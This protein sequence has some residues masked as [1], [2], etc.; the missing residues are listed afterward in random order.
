MWDLPR[1]GIAPMS[2][3]L[4]AWFFTTEQPGKPYLL[5]STSTAPL[6]RWQ[7]TILNAQHSIQN[8]HY[9]MFNTEDSK[10]HTWYIKLNIQHS[11]QDT[12]APKSLLAYRLGQLLN[13]LLDTS[14]I[15]KLRTS[16]I[17]LSS[18]T[19]PVSPSIFSTSVDDQQPQSL[20]NCQVIPFWN[21]FF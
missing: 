10:Y 2:S 3:A 13:C 14:W 19:K 21:I 12:G 1:S 7:Y 15:P 16:K 8:T 4:A 17:K 9:I 20:L 18:H 11:I 6:Y 5:S